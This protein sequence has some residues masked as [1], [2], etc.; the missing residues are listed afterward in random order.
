MKI[1]RLPTLMIVVLLYLTAAPVF[2]QAPTPDTNPGGGGASSPIVVAC[3]DGKNAPCIQNV[4][5]VGDIVG[6]WR[7]YLRGGTGIGFTVYKNDG[8][9]SGRGAIR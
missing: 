7:S 3:V 2:A 1:Y 5:E 6:V 9:C 4:D 8:D